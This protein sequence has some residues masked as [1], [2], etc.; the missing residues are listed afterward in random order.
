MVTGPAKFAWITMLVAGCCTLS[1]AAYA[2]GP[3]D[4]VKTLPSVTHTS[5]F[6]TTTSDSDSD[7]NRSYQD[8][9]NDRW[10]IDWQPKPVEVF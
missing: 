5:D 9:Y 2:A 7:S 1:I 3:R 4:A 8:L 6:H 10:D